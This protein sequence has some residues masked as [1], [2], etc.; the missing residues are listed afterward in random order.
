MPATRSKT[1]RSMNSSWIKAL[2]AS[3]CLCVLTPVWAADEPPSGS[4]TISSKSVAV[5]VGVTW[6]R[7]TLSYGGAQ[8]RFSVKG[9][10]LV[11]LGISHIHTSGDVFHLNNLPDFSGP[12]VAG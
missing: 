1:M 5:G 9:L 4:V 7:G 10:S 6:G 2:A 11:D 12:Y 8:H 3:A